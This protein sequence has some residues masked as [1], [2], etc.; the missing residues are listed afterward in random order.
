MCRVQTPPHAVRKGRRPRLRRV[1]AGP[2]SPPPPPLRRAGTGRAGPFR[3]GSNKGKMAAAAAVALTALGVTLGVTLGLAAAA[4]CFLRPVPL[5]SRPRLP[6]RARLVAHRGGSGEKIENT[7]EA[8]ENAVTHGA[9]LLELD[10]RRT[11]DGVVVVSHDGNLLR[12]SGRP[13]DLRRLRYQDLPPYKSPLEVT[14]YPGHFSSG[15]DR[16][17]PRLDEVFRR[18]PHVPI[19]IE[20]KDDDDDLIN[21]VAALVR[22]HD[23]A[24]ITLWASFHER[25]LRKCRRAHPAMPYGFSLRRGLLLLLLHY[26]GLLPFVPLGEAALLSSLPAII[27]RTYFPVPKGWAGALLSKVLQAVTM[28]PALLRHLRDRGIQVVLWVLNEE[29]DFA[30]AFAAGA[31]GAMT[32]YPQRLGGYLRAAPPPP[33]PPPPPRPHGA[34]PPAPRPP[35]TRGIDPAPPPPPGADN[36]S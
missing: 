10:C 16:R 15:A 25:I 35:L 8:F 9:D 28:R 34:A 14:F 36:S 32:D 1:M 4:R 29:R 2:G 30:G 7:M 22:R 27:N 12:Q 3:R 23:R 11:L 13:L 6:F 24:A 18:F 19:S 33:P 31:S 20:I 5:P 21:E 26:S 17:I